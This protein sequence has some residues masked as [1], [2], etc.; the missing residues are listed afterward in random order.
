MEQGLMEATSR[1]IKDKEASGE[2]RDG[3]TKGN[4]HLPN[5]IAPC[6]ETICSADE[7]LWLSRSQQCVRSSLPRHNCG[8]AGKMWTGQTTRW[9]KKLAKLLISKGGGLMTLIV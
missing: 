4:S 5:L 3:F 6:H 9:V 2:S 1:Y 8:Q 7:E